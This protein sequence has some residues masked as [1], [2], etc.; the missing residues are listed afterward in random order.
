MNKI[1]LALSLEQIVLLK[2]Y[3]RLSLTLRKRKGGYGD[4]LFFL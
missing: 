1:L 2:E 3:L 4:Y